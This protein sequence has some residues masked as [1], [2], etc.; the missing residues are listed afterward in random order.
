MNWEKAKAYF[1]EVYRKHVNRLDAGELEPHFA[2]AYTLDPLL[3]RY[4]E[5]ERSEPLYEAMLHLGKL[6]HKN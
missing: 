6:Y 3:K 1:D 4:E 5:G 2:L